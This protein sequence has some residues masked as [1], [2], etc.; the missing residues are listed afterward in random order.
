MQLN[1]PFFSSSS[2]R[3][4]RRRRRR[5]KKHK[6]DGKKEEER[7]GR[8]DR[9]GGKKSNGLEFKGCRSRFSFKLLENSLMNDVSVQCHI[10]SAFHFSSTFFPS[11]S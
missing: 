11:S 7:E 10:S 8:V 2:S 3:E 4:G 5:K 6:V 1:E 9:R